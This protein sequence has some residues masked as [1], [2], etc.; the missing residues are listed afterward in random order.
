MTKRQIKARRKTNK[1]R[2]CKQSRGQGK[3]PIAI[4]KP[5]AMGWNKKY[6]RSDCNNPKG[7]SQKNCQGRKRENMEIN[8]LVQIWNGQSTGT[9]SY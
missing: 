1:G 4:T 5:K 9:I 7:F 8:E 2:D 3:K 6:K